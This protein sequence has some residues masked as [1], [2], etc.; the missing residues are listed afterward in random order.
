MTTTKTRKPAPK[1]TLNATWIE[2][3]ARPAGRIARISLV[4]AS[5]RE[6]AGYYQL[7]RI[8]Q[9]T[10]D[11]IAYQVAEIGDFGVINTIQPYETMISVHNDQD[12]ACTCLGHQHTGHCK[13]VGAIKVLLAA[14]LNCIT[15]EADYRNKSHSAEDMPF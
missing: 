15:T 10:D 11:T 8:E 7:T 4:H 2:T 1:P 6:D 12:H 13:H 5:G 14:D 3:D 9:P